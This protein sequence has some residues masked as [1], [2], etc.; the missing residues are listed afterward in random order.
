MSSGVGLGAR[1]CSQPNSAKSRELWRSER[2]RGK[3]TSRSGGRR[4]SHNR[5]VSVPKFA[6]KTVVVSDFIFPTHLQQP[7]ITSQSH[8]EYQQLP[9]VFNL[10]CPVHVSAAGK[11]IVKK[12]KI[13]VRQRLSSCST[14]YFSATF[15]VSQASDCLA[16]LILHFISRL[17]LLSVVIRLP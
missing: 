7:W 3:S 11:K 9:R 17:Q 6:S 10:Q 13:P 12:Y 8:F 4:G 5:A 2:R 16:R 14:F 15:S 1:T